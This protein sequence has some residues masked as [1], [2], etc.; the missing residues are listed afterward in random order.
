MQDF[1]Y[2]ILPLH[3]VCETKRELLNQVFSM[4]E[5][6]FGSV[7]ND[8][9]HELDFSDFCR[10]H[11]A[12]VI[13]YKDEIVGF[14]LFTIFDF[15]LTSHLRHPYVSELSSAT[16]A[17]LQ[18]RHCTRLMTM[19]YFTVGFSWRRKY[20]DVP[21]AEIL[22]GLGLQYLDYS[23]ANGVLGT[24]RTDIKVDQMCYRLGA[25]EIQP[26]IKKMKY[27]CAVVLFEKQTRRHFSNEV[28][29]FWVKRL[30]KDYLK[31]KLHPKSGRASRTSMQDVQKQIE[32]EF[33]VA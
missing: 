17:Y 20:R 2:E 14:N 29:H 7:L 30:W 31:E 24:P 23:P 10:C 1:H 8:K 28:T 13:R 5:Q 19:E 32:I 6:T 3:H 16:V 22:T 18:S 33:E 27:E 4:W 11:A 26:P 15:S 25:K 9:G 21:W 12:G